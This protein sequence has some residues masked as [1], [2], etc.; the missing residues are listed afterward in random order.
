MDETVAEQELMPERVL[1]KRNVV[2]TDDGEESVDRSGATPRES[3]RMPLGRVARASDVQSAI[4]GDV[5]IRPAQQIGEFRGQGSENRGI[6]NR[7][8]ENTSRLS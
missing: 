1:A 6:V 4:V 5:A 3:E 2:R 7:R 8:A